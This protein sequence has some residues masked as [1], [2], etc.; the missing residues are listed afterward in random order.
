DLFG[1]DGAVRLHDRVQCIGHGPWFDA[2][3]G[4][5]SSASRQNAQSHYND[6]KDYLLHFVLISFDVAG[7]RQGQSRLLFA[8][9]SPL[10]AFD[11]ARRALRKV[12]GNRRSE[13]RRV[14]KEEKLERLARQEVK[15]QV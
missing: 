15:R 12:G 13:E 2:G 3:A 10:E 7:N 4:L 6:S 11:V 1:V 9:S 5:L 8:T 14:G